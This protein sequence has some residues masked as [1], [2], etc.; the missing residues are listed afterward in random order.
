[1]RGRVCH[2]S[3]S[4]SS[5]MSIVIIYNFYTLHV[6][7]VVEYIWNIHIQGLCQSGLSTADYALFLVAFAT[8][9]FQS[10]ER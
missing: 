3:E 4:V 1:M 6:L 8:M 5:I 7:H 2:L 10:L 9:A